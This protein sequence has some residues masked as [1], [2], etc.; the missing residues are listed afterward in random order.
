MKRQF[1]LSA[2]VGI[3]SSVVLVASENTVSAS[4]ASNTFTYAING[5]PE[6]TN[7]LTTSD[8]W[9]L[10]F[11]NIQYSPLF[12]V[13]SEGKFTNALA[14]KY[15][16]S[17]DGKTITIDLRHGVK[18]SDGQPLTA[19]DVVFTYN[20]KED[21]ATGNSDALYINGQAVKVEK[22]NDNQVKFIL[23]TKSASALNNIATETYILPEHI[24]KNTKDLNQN[25][26]TPNNVGTGPYK[27]V[28]YKQGEYL[29]FVRNDNFFGT[30]PKIKNLTLRIITS[31]DTTKI[32][33]QK[34]DV[35]ASFVL[36]SDLKNLKNDNLKVYPFSENRIGYLGLNTKV[37][38][39]SNVKVRRAVFYAI[40][41]SQINKATYLNKKYY[42]TPNSFL[43]PENEF[44]SKNV[45]EYAHNIK[46]AKSLL[47]S[48]GVKKLSFNLAFSSADPAQKIQATLIQ[49]QLKSVGITVKLSGGDATAI[50]TELHKVGQT[51]YAAFLNGYIMGN[52]PDQYKPLF[53][54]NGTSNYWQYN[55]KKIDSLFTKGNTESTSKERTKTYK[56]L[57]K[58]INKAAT[59][60]P[61]TDNKKILVVNKKYSN[62]KDARLIPIYTFQDWSKLA[63]K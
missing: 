13:D 42:N 58:T 54:S 17:A 15:T 63:E 27:L 29:K 61:I 51:K 56:K 59:V 2:L 19:D 43:P 48:A 16:T 33:L 26:L 35:D 21:K 47:K 37:K 5:D 8:R 55:S 52:D 32:A 12:Y 3:V 1:I 28:T 24:Y 14:D 62:V 39:L 41:K 18:W 9:G 6:S 49:Q 23:P 22:V 38:A 57:Q 60:Y 44:A 11:S 25:S 10:T 36:P 31:A 40:N 7:P 34:G 45:D 53:Q 4:T 46:K 30:K 20:K 50:S